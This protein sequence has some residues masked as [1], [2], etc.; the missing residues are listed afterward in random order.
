MSILSIYFS[1]FID[2]SDSIEQQDHHN[3]HSVNTQLTVNKEPKPGI[4]IA[5]KCSIG[6]VIQ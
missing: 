2:L 4:E 1:L 5:L 6:K 3:N